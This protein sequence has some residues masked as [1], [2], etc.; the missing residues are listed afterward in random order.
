[1]QFEDT[2]INKFEDLIGPIPIRFLRG[3]FLILG[4]FI[5]L[6]I[7]I[8]GFVRVPD[9]LESTITITSLNP[10]VLVRPEIDGIIQDLLVADKKNV[11][12][13]QVLAHIDLEIEVEEIQKIEASLPLIQNYQSAPD[14]AME[15]CLPNGH[16]EGELETILLSIHQNIEKYKRL[17]QDPYYAQRRKI[18]ADQLAYRKNLIQLLANELE[19]KRSALDLEQRKF[20]VDQSLY[21]SNLISKVQFLE[22]QRPYLNTE[23][24]VRN[25]Q[26][27]IEQNRLDI[28][29]IKNN[30]NSLEIDYLREIKTLEDK[31]DEEVLNLYSLVHSLEHQYQ[32]EAP[33][34]GLLEY[35]EA[36]DEG[37]MVSG[38][39][40]VFVITPFNNE[41][42][43]KISVP[44]Y[45][46]ADLEVGQTVRIKLEK[47]PFE[48]WGMLQGQVASITNVP[49]NGEYRV[50]VS[51]PDGFITTYGKKLSYTNQ[52]EGQVEIILEK[53]SFFRKIF[54]HFYKMTQ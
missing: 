42:I 48:D 29:E 44:E 45:N 26:T 25:Q 10:P 20:Q 19:S 50:K 4:G 40:P 37:Q 14:Q 46:T 17:K 8:I 28:Q 9:K 33:T 49:I 41:T 6:I 1:M 7:L 43:G 13:K 52:L 51:F 27:E 39:D 2:K 5:L 32:I 22:A 31:I 18:L 36:L 24:E 35:F 47:Y 16:I 54:N 38:Q 11:R 3:S 53:K 12:K 34:E 15:A 21:D 30:I 23:F